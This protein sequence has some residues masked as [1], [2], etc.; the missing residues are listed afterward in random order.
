VA[1][2]AI[3]LL[4]RASL[5]FCSIFPMADDPLDLA[6]AALKEDMPRITD[7]AKNLTAILAG[8]EFARADKRAA[9]SSSSSDA[10]LEIADLLQV[11]RIVLKHINAYTFP[12]P[13]TWAA[14]N[15]QGPEETAMQRVETLTNYRAAHALASHA[16]SQGAKLTKLLGRKFLRA[17]FSW[18][19]IRES[20]NAD[21]ALRAFPRATVEAFLKGWGEAI[22][23]E[24]GAAGDVAE[25][26]WEAD[27]PAALQERRLARQQEVTERLERMADGE[28][29][30]SM[31]RAALAGQGQGGPTVAPDEDDDD[32]PRLTEVDAE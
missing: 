30:A 27:L 15:P 20:I 25:L 14:D 24:A 3:L 31:L 32:E 19:A 26:V 21:S 23:S 17:T 8:N 2:R 13:S 12:E 10:P 6:V 1:P 9:G 16:S 28:S 7:A 4:Q 11:A 29:E 5:S 18:A 22:D